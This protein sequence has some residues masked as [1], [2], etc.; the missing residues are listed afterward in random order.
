MTRDLLQRH[1]FV[2]AVV[3]AATLLM[4]VLVPAGWMPAIA[5]GQLIT[6]CSGMGEA[7]VWIDADG[8]P[9][10]APHDKDPAGDGTCVFAGS[11]VG[12]VAPLAQCPACP[13]LII[14]LDL[15]SRIAAAVGHGLAAPPP[16]AIGPPSLN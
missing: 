3:L 14:V 7:K 8:N 12:F 16:P 4:R 15:P 1:R 9:V 6:I 2:F 5:D 10:E 13:L 11:L